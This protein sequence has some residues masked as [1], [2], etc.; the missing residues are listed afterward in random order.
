MNTIL[1][2]L[3]CL[4]FAGCAVPGDEQTVSLEKLSDPNDAPYCIGRNPADPWTP[5]RAAQELAEAYCAHHGDVVNCTTVVFDGWC[6]NNPDCAK[7]YC[8]PTIISLAQWCISETTTTGFI[9]GICWTLFQG[10]A[11]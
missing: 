8:T 7:F 5:D 4:A 10:A 1:V 6:H 2:G 11:S 9:P 3:A